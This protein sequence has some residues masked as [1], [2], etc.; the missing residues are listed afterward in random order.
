MKQTLTAAA[1]A[2]GATGLGATGALAEAEAYTLDPA[3]ARSCSRTITS[4]FSTTYG[5]FSGFEGEI[6]FDEEDPA[7]SS[8]NVSMPLMSMFTGWE[9]R[10]EHFM[11][12]DFFDAAEG[13][14]ITF[15]STGIEVT[16]ENTAQITG[17]LSMN[18]VTQSVVLDTTLNKQASHPMQNKP[19]L[20]FDAST[21]LLRSDFGVGNFAPVVSD[22]IEVRFPSRRKRPG[23]PSNTGIRV[24]SFVTSASACSD[25]YR[26]VCPAGGPSFFALSGAVGAGRGHRLFGRRDQRV[27]DEIEL[28]PG[29]AG[30]QAHIAGAHQHGAGPRQVRRL[31]GQELPVPEGARIVGAEAEDLHLDAA[32]RGGL[33]EGACVG[34]GHPHEVELDR[35]RRASSGGSFSGTESQAQVLSRPA[36]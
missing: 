33:G 30:G 27:G 24:T 34:I 19:W 2:M 4:A 26:A 15:T 10:E 23:Q 11:S 21:T 22:E 3:T 7:N 13:D 25:A 12:E 36:T 6:M 17:D 31:A 18:G 5:M 16:G 35:I 8:V 14:M 9:E 32:R 1:L 28:W 29:Q 20:G